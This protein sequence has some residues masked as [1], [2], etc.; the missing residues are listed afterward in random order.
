[1]VDKSPTL[2]HYWY[3]W[4]SI[5]IIEGLIFKRFMTKNGIEEHTQCI[6]PLKLKEVVLKNV[7]NSVISGHLG[8]TKTKGKVR[9][10]YYWYEMKEDIAI[11]ISKCEICGANKPHQN[12]IE[13]H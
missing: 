9:Q 12:H 4:D 5:E 11:W 8:K 13:P 2:R 1:M 7:H 3:L 10:K 6:V